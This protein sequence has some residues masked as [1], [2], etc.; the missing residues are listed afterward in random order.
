MKLVILV[1][2][3]RSN[4]RRQVLVGRACGRLSS[5]RDLRNRLLESRRTRIFL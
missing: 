1:R 4:R 3:T 5:R 2:G